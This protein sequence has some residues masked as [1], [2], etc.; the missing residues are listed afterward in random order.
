MISNIGL[1]IFWTS[2][3]TYYILGAYL[4]VYYELY[5]DISS[6]EF[7]DTVKMENENENVTKSLISDE[8]WTS[9]NINDM[10]S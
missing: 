5:K 6:S 2:S 3:P 9:G 10:E 4:K 8:K 7:S 1:C